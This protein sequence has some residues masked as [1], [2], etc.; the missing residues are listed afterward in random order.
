MDNNTPKL[1]GPFLPIDP[2]WWPAIT[3]TFEGSW[4]RESAAIDLRFYEMEVQTGRRASM[5]AKRFFIKRWGWTDYKTRQL[6][7]DEQYW[8][9]WDATTQKPPRN[10]PE[11]AQKRTHMS[12]IEG[13]TTQETPRNHP[14][15]TR[16]AAHRGKELKNLRVKQQQPK[17]KENIRDRYE[18]QR[19]SDMAD[20]ISS[21]DSW[22]EAQSQIESLYICESPSRHWRPIANPQ[23]QNLREY[24]GLQ[25]QT[26]WQRR[27][28]SSPPQ[29]APPPQAS[30]ADSVKEFAHDLIKAV[31]HPGEQQAPSEPSEPSLPTYDYQYEAH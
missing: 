20:I 21:A 1:K 2:R 17:E 6:M 19:M 11:T 10:R 16:G 18:A 23:W 26:L 13:N 4:I 7:K 12:S 24:T 9:A 8:S 29:A 28:A 25:A 14:E 3:Q 27:A 30:E 5:P 15:I 31:R 22:P